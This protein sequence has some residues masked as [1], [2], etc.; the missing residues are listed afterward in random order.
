MRIALVSLGLLLFVTGCGGN[1]LG[2]GG[3]DLGG[4]PV[5]VGGADMAPPGK[6]AGDFVSYAGATTDGYAVVSDR[7]GSAWAIRLADGSQ[8]KI[9]DHAVSFLP[10]LDVV[11]VVSD[12]VNGYGRLSLWR[13]GTAVELAASSPDSSFGFSP[14]T[15]DD[16][17]H[18][19]YYGNGANGTSDLIVDKID[20]SAPRVLLS[21]ID[22]TNT[23]RCWP[24]LRFFGGRLLVSHCNDPSGSAWTLSSFDPDSGASVDLASPSQKFFTVDAK[25]GLFVT[26]P[27]GTVSLVDPRGGPLR[28]F[29]DNVRHLRL[30]NGGATALVTTLSGAL[31]RVAVADGSV[32]VL[33]PSGVDRVD[34]LSGDE[35]TL[36]LTTQQSPTTFLNDLYL[37]SATQAGPRTTLNS[38]LTSFSTGYGFTDDSSWALYLVDTDS[39]TDAGAL[40]ARPA[41]GGAERALGQ[42]S[43]LVAPMGGARLAFGQQYDAASNLT[44]ISFVDLARNDPPTLLAKRAWWWFDVGTDNRTVIWLVPGD[45][46][47]IHAVP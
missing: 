27:T 47:Y 42:G 22:L 36:L 18:I 5:V 7:A 6:V 24:A 11:F 19:A 38:A 32:T 29:A 37:A 31:Q 3:A 14:P 21:G 39:T 8:Q 25:A 17:G 12:V 45:G 9:V 40:R 16:A 20:H 13:A 41:S 26:S 34:S 30:I 46:L 28:H 4:P 44:D 1:P 2:G 43:Q 23:S 15:R 10:Y 33:Q 35:Q